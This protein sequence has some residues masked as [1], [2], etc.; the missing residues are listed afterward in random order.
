MTEINTLTD[1]NANHVNPLLKEIVLRTIRKIMRKSYNW[2][3]YTM[4][5]NYITY[6][7]SPLIRYRL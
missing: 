5:N 4:I 3:F 2:T 1:T 7:I 6:N